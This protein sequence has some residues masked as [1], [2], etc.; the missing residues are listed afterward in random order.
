MGGCLEHLS[1]RTDLAELAEIH[2]RDS[3]A[4][5]LHYGEV[6]GDEDEGEPVARLHVLEQVENLRA[7]GNIERRDWLVANDELRLEH[8]CPGD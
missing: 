8:K 6:V 4:Y 1:G 7:D 2:H 3:V 5:R